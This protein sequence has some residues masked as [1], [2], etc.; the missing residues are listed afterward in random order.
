MPEVYNF[1]RFLHRCPEVDCFDTNKYPKVSE[2]VVFRMEEYFYDDD[3]SDAHIF[4]FVTVNGS[5]EPYIDI[6]I[7]DMMLYPC[8][9]RRFIISDGLRLS[10]DDEKCFLSY[11]Y[12]DHLHVEE[13]CFENMVEAVIKN[14]PTL[15]YKYY[16]V[17]D[18]KIAFDHIYYASHRSGVKEILYKAGLSNIAFKINEIP[19]YNLIGTSPDSIIGNNISIKLLR[20]LNQPEFNG[21]L[22]TEGEIEHCK[23]I[24]NHYSGYIGKDLPSLSQWAYLEKLFDNEGIL[25]RKGFNR[26]LYEYLSYYCD[27]D[28]LGDYE[29]FFMLREEYSDIIKQKIPKPDEVYG[30][31]E[32]FEMLENLKGKLNYLDKTIKR[33]KDKNDYEYRGDNYSVIMPGSILDFFKEAVAHGKWVMDYIDEHASGKITILFVRRNEEIDRSFV[34]LEIRN[35]ILS[36]VLFAWL[37]RAADIYEFLIDYI[38]KNYHIFDPN[39]LIITDPYNHDYVTDG[40]LMEYVKCHPPKS[41]CAYEMFFSGPFYKP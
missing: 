9:Y 23:E 37:Y 22:C 31:V 21:K 34:I 41:K 19:S 1:E 25:A 12:N 8:N 18:Q 20:I 30:I 38:E 39:S 14:F 2:E 6:Y 11:I 36:R 29:K 16:S 40:G 17:Q 5:G 35:R 32:V 10:E 33:R 7:L 15:N 3:C 28:I 24:Y 4:P 27:N 13:K 26:T